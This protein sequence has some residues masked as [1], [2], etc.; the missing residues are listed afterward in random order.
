MKLLV[1]FFLL[2]SIPFARAD[3]DAIRI[4]DET[5]RAYDSI[6]KNNYYNKTTIYY[7]TCG[8]TVCGKNYTQEDS[9]M[10]YYVVSVLQQQAKRY[11]LM[12]ERS[13][14]KITFNSTGYS[15]VYD[16]GRRC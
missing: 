12:D 10:I 6:Y 9:A 15:G 11:I 16:H 2:V 13:G 5:A 1:F 8:M 14:W 3:I 4:D 7:V